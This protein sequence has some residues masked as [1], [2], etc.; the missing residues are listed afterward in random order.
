ME[1]YIR[2]R[3]LAKVYR[4]G[5]SDLV[6]FSGL[7]LDVERGEMLALVGESGAGKSTLLHL[8]GGLDR[9]SNGTIHYGS[10]EISGLADSERADFRNREIGFVWQIHY[11]LPEF[12]ALENVMMPLLIRGRTGQQAA[13]ES[14]ARLDEV[15][16][17]A[18]AGHRA[19]EL[20]GGEQQRVVLARALVGKPSVL[21]ADEP[22]GN[23]D[24]RTGEMIFE[25]LEGLHRSHGLTSV[26]VTHNMEFARRCDRVL[27]L[28]RGGLIPGEPDVSQPGTRPEYL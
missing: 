7:N 22:T 6:I 9:P 16:L 23:L 20:S 8:L 13:A 2:A 5:A 4:S 28:S 27:H 14:M 19:G 10:R 1:A 11:L 15:G 26:F 17:G 25:L 12:T 18:R 3:N 24:F 21:L